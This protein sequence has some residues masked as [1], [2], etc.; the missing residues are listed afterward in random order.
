MRRAVRTLVLPAA[1]AAAPAGLPAAARADAPPTPA[2]HVRVVATTP[3]L[4]ARA[5]ALAAKAPAIVA[6]AARRLFLPPPAEIEILVAAAVPPPDAHQPDALEPPRPWVGGW[7][8]TSASR[9]VLYADRTPRYPHE[10]L[11][12]LLAHEAAHLILAGSLP[13]GR[14]VPRW[15]SEGLA[16]LAERDVSWRDALTLARTELLSAPIP[17]DALDRRWP[18]TGGQAAAAYAQVLSMLSFA[19]RNAPPASPR[20]LIEALRNG[21]DFDRAFTAAY[22]RSPA[23]TWH[24]WRRSLRWRY[25]ILPIVVAAGLAPALIG[26]LALAA[27]AVAFRRR[28]RQYAD[29]ERREREEAPDGNGDPR[30]HA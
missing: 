17:L 30:F 14:R 4:E 12:G 21:L 6:R 20:R 22:G 11:E 29:L 10:G 15:Y 8:D 1:L 24:A 13:A 2:A 19:E 27:S 3:A 28:A 7:A 5:Q 25:R 23:Q 9:I 18:A 16:M 26:M